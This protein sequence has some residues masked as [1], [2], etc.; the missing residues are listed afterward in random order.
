MTDYGAALCQQLAGPCLDQYV[1]AQVLTALEPAALELSLEAAQQ[2]ERARV[3]RDRLWQQ[4]RERAA[5]EAERARRQ[6]DAVEPENRLV[7]RHLERAWDEKLAAQQDLEEEY[8]RFLATPPR[9]LSDGERVAIRQLAADIPALWH[10]PTTTLAERKELIR[11]VVQRVEA[12]VQG[13]SERVGV[14]ITWAGGLQTAGEMVREMVRPV[15]RFSQLSYYAALRDQVEQ[16]AAA[17]LATTEMAQRLNAAGYRPPKRG[18]QF[19]APIVQDLLRQLQRRERRRHPP[20][21]DGPGI[22]EWWLADRARSIGMPPVTLDRWLR[23]GWLTARQGQ[24]PPH[25]WIVWADEVEVARLQ[26][27]H[28]RPAGYATRQRWVDEEGA[29]YATAGDHQAHEAPAEAPRAPRRLL[30][31]QIAKRG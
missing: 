23:R 28:Q 24:R 22:H 25:R 31:N 20:R 8:H 21:S 18:A 7:A 9:G 16:W 27:L 6:Y 12:T 15:A 17:G 3:D 5:Y 29:G 13:D 26:A 4:R 1:S 30:G 14:A 19:T 10:A 11:Q 2:V